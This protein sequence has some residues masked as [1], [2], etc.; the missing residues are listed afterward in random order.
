LHNTWGDALS[1]ADLFQHP[2]IHQLAAHLHQQ[3]QNVTP[4]SDKGDARVLRLRQ[5]AQAQR[6]QARLQER[7][8]LA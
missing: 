5:A 6:R 4:E 7:E 3:K 2:T 1:L 8:K